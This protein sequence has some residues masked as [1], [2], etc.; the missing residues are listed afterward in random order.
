METNPTIRESDH[1]DDEI[2][3]GPF[4]RYLKS[5]QGHEI[6]K[7]VIIIFEQLRTNGFAQNTKLKAIDTW[8]RY[9]LVL[10]VIIA[11]VVLSLYDKFDSTIGVLFGTLI[12]Y[13]FGR[14][15]K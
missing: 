1:K 5:E 7:Q 11:A 3:L 12:G 15:R 8:L 4:F 2:D 6:A 13:F 10:S 14:T 9:V